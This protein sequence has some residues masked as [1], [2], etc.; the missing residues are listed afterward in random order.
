MD[1]IQLVIFLV[2]FVIGGV[3]EY[4]WMLYRG[5]KNE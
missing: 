3:T 2:G 5:F 1:K 4:I